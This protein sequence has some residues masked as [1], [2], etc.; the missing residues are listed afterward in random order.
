MSTILNL[1]ACPWKRLLPCAFD[2]CR[3]QKGVKVAS[4]SMK[5]LVQQG[6]HGPSVWCS[7]R[8]SFQAGRPEFDRCFLKIS[9][10]LRQLTGSAKQSADTGSAL[11]YEYF[12]RMNQKLA[13]RAR[14]ELATLRLTVAAL[15]LGTKCDDLLS[16]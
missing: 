4:T 1:N 15:I 2:V 13:P 11:T 5:T 8:V 9:Y 14:F 3:G 6:G 7:R 16:C 12:F 10:G